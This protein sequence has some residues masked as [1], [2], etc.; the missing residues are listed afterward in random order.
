MIGHA[1]INGVDI[2]AGQLKPGIR[3]GDALEL[4]WS[5]RSYR[6]RCRAWYVWRA[7]ARDVWDFF[8]K[9]LI[10][11]GIAVYPLIQILDVFGFV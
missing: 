7:Y 3:R 10:V 9:P 2:R 6:W 1:S 8:K 5:K 4:M 11:T